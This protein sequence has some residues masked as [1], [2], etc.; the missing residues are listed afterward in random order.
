M[1]FLVTCQT[2]F[3]SIY[4]IYKIISN[5]DRLEHVYNTMYLMELLWTGG[6]WKISVEYFQSENQIFFSRS[7]HQ[8]FKGNF[9]VVNCFLIDCLQSGRSPHLPPDDTFRIL[10][11]LER[12]HLPSGRMTICLD[13]LRKVARTASQFPDRHLHTL[14]YCRSR[15]RK[16]PQDASPPT[17]TSLSS[18]PSYVLFIFMLTLTPLSSQLLTYPVPPIT[19]EQL[20]VEYCPIGA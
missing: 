15:R 13:R 4:M 2:F 7:S 10:H 6:V 12:L 1:I 14:R 19:D 16:S 17:K 11:R 20:L 18:W 9:L 8:L 5:H 3:S